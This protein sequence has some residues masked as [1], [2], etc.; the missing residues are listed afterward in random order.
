M[1]VAASE[2]PQV[3]IED[4]VQV[5]A[6]YMSAT[7]TT[8]FEMDAIYG[9][10]GRHLYDAA[11]S[12]LKSYTGTFD[13]LLKMQRTLRHHG[14][15][16]DAQAKGVLNCIAAEV[17]RRA[18]AANPVEDDNTESINLSTVHNGTYTI[19]MG[20][21]DN[22]RTLRIKPWATRGNGVRIVQWMS[23]TDNESSFEG[24]ATIFADGT[25]QIWHR[26]ADRWDLATALEMLAAATPD[27][28][29]GFRE[30]YAMRSG[31]CAMCGRKLTVPVSLHR[32]IGPECHK[33]L[34]GKGLIA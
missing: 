23:G 7:N 33:L 28:Q 30:G 5:V 17:R 34:L 16:T 22:W 18:A 19:L 26:M 29:G 11:V 20:S 15:P 1:A 12:F 3:I 6:A 10:H 13:Y 2:Q 4:P 8:R 27:E 32:G 31:R 9:P 24:F 25:V 21:D 14:G